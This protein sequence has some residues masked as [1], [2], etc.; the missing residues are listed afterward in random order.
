[1]HVFW[2]YCKAAYN[3][4]SNK[5]T[6]DDASWFKGDDSCEDDPACVAL[7]S[8]TFADEPTAKLHTTLVIQKWTLLFQVDSKIQ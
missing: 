4:F 5:D 1:M 3:W 2:R 8:P 6:C 7:R